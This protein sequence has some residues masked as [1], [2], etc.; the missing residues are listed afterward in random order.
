M[1]TESKRTF[2]VNMRRASYFLD[3]HESIHG[4]VQGA[5]QNPVRELPRASVVFAVGALDA[6]LSDVS[7][8]VLVH[9]LQ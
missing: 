4:G 9:L 6:Y 2:D 1:P 3:L 8:E 5:P 7:A